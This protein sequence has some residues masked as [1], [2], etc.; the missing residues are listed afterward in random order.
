M[1]PS[2]GIPPP[3]ADDD[4]VM[5][6]TCGTACLHACKLLGGRHVPVATPNRP[7]GRPH[8]NAIIVFGPCYLAW[9]KI[10]SKVHNNV[11]IPRL[12]IVSSC[13]VHTTH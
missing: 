5:C 13:I 3:A 10:D 4:F 1:A 12:T 11:R 8:E 7:T 2:F 6:S 9:G